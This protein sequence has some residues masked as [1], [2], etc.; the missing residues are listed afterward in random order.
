[1]AVLV[2]SAALGVAV[3]ST[4]RGVSFMAKKSKAVKKTAQKMAKKAVAKVVKKS[5]KKSVKKAVKKVVKKVV[6]NYKHYMVLE[7]M[8]L[9]HYMTL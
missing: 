5:V 3:L 8:K 1:V 2:V 9:T 6:K 7:I 4:L